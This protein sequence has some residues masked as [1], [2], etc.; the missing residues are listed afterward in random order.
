MSRAHII[1]TLSMTEERYQ[2]FVSTINLNLKTNYDTNVDIDVL[3]RELPKR[4]E[5]LIK[6]GVTKKT[7]TIILL[8]LCFISIPVLITLACFLLN[9][10]VLSAII[11]PIIGALISLNMALNTSFE[12]EYLRATK[13]Y[14]INNIACFKKKK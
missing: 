11:V 8:A 3:E 2:D 1:A 4:I 13:K 9:I 10:Y 6:E 5:N 12:L 14:V 7:V